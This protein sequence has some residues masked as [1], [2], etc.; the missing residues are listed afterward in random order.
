MNNLNLV[1]CELLLGVLHRVL[2]IRVLIEIL[3]LLSTPT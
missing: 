2:D 3:K 1:R